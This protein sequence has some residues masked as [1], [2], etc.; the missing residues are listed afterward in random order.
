MQISLFTMFDKLNMTRLVRSLTI[1]TI[2]IF[3]AFL[4]NITYEPTALAADNYNSA[5]DTYQETRN[6]NR[7]NSTTEELAKSK[8]DVP[9][10]TEGESIYDRVVDRVNK[11]ETATKESNKSDSRS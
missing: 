9:E 2:A 1:A 3:G 10:K 11:Q 5:T 4:L 7:V 6:P 8:L